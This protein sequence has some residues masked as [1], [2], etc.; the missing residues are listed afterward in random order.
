[1]IATCTVLKSTPTPFPFPSP[2]FPPPTPHH[3]TPHYPTQP[4]P[5]QP[6]PQPTTHPP[7][8][9]SVL[10]F[11]YLLLIL[12]CVMCS[13]KPPPPFP[14]ARAGR[15][16]GVRWAWCQEECRTPCPWTWECSLIAKD[17]LT[18]FATQ[19]PPDQRPSFHAY[20]SVVRVPFS[21]GAS[22]R[23]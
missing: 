12:L 23:R 8:F 19:L 1:M 13:P 2:L 14:L 10:I 4:N 9:Q 20:S 17:S 5:T 7:P 3:T 11:F 21:V 18:N 22:M 15:Q 16:I 6:N